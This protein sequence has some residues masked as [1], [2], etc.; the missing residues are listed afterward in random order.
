MQS[1]AKSLADG[2]ERGSIPSGSCP[3]WLFASASCPCRLIRVRG[4]IPSGSCPGW[5]VSVCILSVSA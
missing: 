5:A 4:L 2:C 3:G 1:L